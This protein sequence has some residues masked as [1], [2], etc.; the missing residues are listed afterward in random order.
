MHDMDA[1]FEAHPLLMAAGILLVLLVGP[2]VMVLTFARFMRWWAS[3][4]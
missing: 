2:V 3:R 1:L 4:Y